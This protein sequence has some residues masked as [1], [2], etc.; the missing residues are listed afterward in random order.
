MP[1]F[2]IPTYIIKEISFD[3]IFTV[4]TESLWPG[5]KSKIEPMSSLIWSADTGLT[6]DSSIFDKYEPTFFGVVIEDFL[7]GVNSGFRTDKHA[8]RSRGLWVDLDHRGLGLGQVLL[9]NAISL[10]KKEDCELIW[11]MPRKSALRTY[12]S[13]GFQRHGPWLDKTVEFGPN[14]VSYK[15]L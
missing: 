15:Y 8:Y 12:K 4:W 14:I 6:K 5:R 9:N 3:D 11:S 7:V 1:E 13:V 10:A 2:D